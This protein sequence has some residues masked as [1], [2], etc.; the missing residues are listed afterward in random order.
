MSKNSLSI[1]S[2]LHSIYRCR[3]VEHS[4]A[5]VLDLLSDDYQT[6]K[7]I[8]HTKEGSPYQGPPN[9][10]VDAVWDRLT[11][12]IFRSFRHISYVILATGRVH[13]M[14]LMNEQLDHSASTLYFSRRSMRQSMQ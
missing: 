11:T 3:E 4:L 9:S 2:H 13:I 8:G 10:K 12:G 5:P 1:V 7:F 6:L 14:T